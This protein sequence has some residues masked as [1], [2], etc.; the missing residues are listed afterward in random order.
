ME[1]EK[2]IKNFIIKGL[3]VNGGKKDNWRQ[4]EDMLKNEMGV[5]AKFECGTEIREWVKLVGRNRKIIKDIWEMIGE[6][7]ERKII[8]GENFN[9]MNGKMIRMNP[10]DKKEG[11]SEFTFISARGESVIDYVI[12]NERGVEGI[13]K[14]RVEDEEESDRQP[15]TEKKSKKKEISDESTMDRRKYKK[16][17]IKDRQR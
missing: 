5:K 9:A 10:L 14:C 16:I 12:Q 11:R 17:Q 15:P 4:V 3:E 13:E 1:R 7:E 6:D 8:I 2:R